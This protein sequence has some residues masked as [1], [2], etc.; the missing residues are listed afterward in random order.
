MQE[1]TASKILKVHPKAFNRSFHEIVFFPEIRLAGKWLSDL[2][3]VAHQKVNVVYS[4]G[5][6][7]ISAIAPE[8]P[9]PILKSRKKKP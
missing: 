3:F 9:A 8:A 5:K 7:E 6:I 1:S 4:E 2:G